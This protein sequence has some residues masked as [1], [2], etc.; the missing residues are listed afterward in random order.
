MKRAPSRAASP[1]STL[2]RGRAIAAALAGVALTPAFWASGSACS[3]GRAPAPSADAGTSPNASILPA[4]LATGAADFDGGRA[5][6]RRGEDASLVRVGDASAPPA[7]L[8]PFEPPPA[9][10]LMERDLSGVMLETLFRMRDMPPFAKGPDVSSEGVREAAQ[11]TTLAASVE[12]A[13]V[14][15]MRLVSKSR[16]LPLPARAELRARTDRLGYAVVWPKRDRYRVLSH[17]ALRALFGERRF[18]VTPLGPAKLHDGADGRRLG[19][20]TRGLRAEGPYGELTLEIGFIPEVGEGGPLLCRVLL[21]LAGIDPLLLPAEPACAPGEV[22]LFAAFTWTGGSGLAFEVTNL[23]KRSDLAADSLALPPPNATFASAGLPEHEGNA[24]LTPRE[25]AALRV[26][27]EVADEAPTDAG[28]REGVVIENRNDVAQ[29]VTLDGLPVAWIPPLS[30][31]A[32]TAL[33]RGRY[34]LQLRTFLG[35]ISGPV[36][37]IDVP[38]RV[39]V[40][41]PDAGVLDA[42]AP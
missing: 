22:P 3:N 23:T 41:G 14:G 20:K 30:E 37:L 19:L 36:H 42:G 13:E 16:A 10:A 29:Y 39:A 25:L 38:A 1:P 4:P 18:D 28:V 40:G 33:P 27:H 15:R 26:P 35:D 8:E 2:R 32:L 11:L 24:F 9:D 31:R 17:G 7:A 34:A 21:E 5:P 12:L 6:A